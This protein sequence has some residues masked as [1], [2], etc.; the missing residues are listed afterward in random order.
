M[1]DCDSC[2]EFNEWQRLR[3]S[4]IVGCFRRITDR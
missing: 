3:A 2:P 4:G 1:A